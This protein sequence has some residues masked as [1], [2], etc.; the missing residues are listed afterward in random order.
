M[1]GQPAPA[2]ARSTCRVACNHSGVDASYLG[3]A[4]SV[5]CAGALLAEVA[6]AARPLCPPFLY[7]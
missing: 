1:Q 3:C 4:C 7:Y 2:S 6:K 5:H